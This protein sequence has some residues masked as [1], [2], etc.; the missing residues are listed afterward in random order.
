MTRLC[1]VQEDWQVRRQAVETI[2]TLAA[3][4]QVRLLARCPFLSPGV[5]N[6]C[7]MLVLAKGQKLNSATKQAFVVS[8]YSGTAV[9]QHLGLT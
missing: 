4:V 1:T 2:I 8:A 7:V 6:A 3:A 9:R 5:W